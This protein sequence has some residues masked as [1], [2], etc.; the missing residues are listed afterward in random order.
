MDEVLL[1]WLSAFTLSAEMPSLEELGLS[2]LWSELEANLEQS[3]HFE[4][5]IQGMQSFENNITAF[6][7]DLESTI[8]VCSHFQNNQV[9]FIMK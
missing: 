7:T 9:G 1:R 4:E 3:R 5:D 8:E 2:D 6:Q